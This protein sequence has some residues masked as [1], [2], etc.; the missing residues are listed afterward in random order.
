MSEAQAQQ[1]TVV[2]P[3]AGRRIDLGGTVVTL[4]LDGPVTGAAYAALNI[5]L[6]PGAGAALHRHRYEDETFAI[7]GGV[8]TFQ[9]GVETRAVGAGGLVFIPRGLL[10]AFRNAGTEHATALIVVTPAGLEQY[11]AELGTLLGAAEQPAAET[12]AALNERYGLEFIQG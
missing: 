11:F 10:H 2:E 12:I 6:A 7:L 3:G 5:A 9:L 4:R 8:I 1:S